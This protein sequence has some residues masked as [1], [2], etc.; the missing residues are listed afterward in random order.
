MAGLGPY[1]T[2]TRSDSSLI[3]APTLYP[4]FTTPA[5][6]SE[7]LVLYANGFDQHLRQWP[8]RRQALYS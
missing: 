4:D 8:A 3:G 5:K 7:V 1:V 2:A 6:Q